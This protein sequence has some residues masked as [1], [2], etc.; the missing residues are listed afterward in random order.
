MTAAVELLA[1][2]VAPAAYT[3]DARMAVACA[4]AARIAVA[5]VA[6]A[7][8]AV[9]FVAVVFVAVAAVAVAFVAVE[10]VAVAAVACTA[11]AEVVAAGVLAIVPVPVAVWIASEPQNFRFYQSLPS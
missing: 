11:L 1:W 4:P 10:F 5:F 7:F 3:V 2:L 6:V 9:A 8:V